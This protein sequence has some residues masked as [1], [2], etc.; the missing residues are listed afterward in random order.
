MQ[1]LMLRLCTTWEQFTNDFLS[2]RIGRDSHNCLY[3]PY[4]CTEQC[5]NM[6]VHNFFIGTTFL[7]CLS[8]QPIFQRR[9][10]FECNNRFCEILERHAPSVTKRDFACNRSNSKKPQEH[11]SDLH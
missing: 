6:L 5:F 4:V 2:I 7:I 9:I 10:K 3:I 1:P 11:G 8:P